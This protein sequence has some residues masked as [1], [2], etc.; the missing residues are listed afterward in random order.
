MKDLLFAQRVSRKWDTVIRGSQALMEALF[1]KPQVPKAFWEHV[2]GPHG[3]ARHITHAELHANKVQTPR[4][5]PGVQEYKSY[6]MAGVL[7]TL[8]FERKSPDYPLATGAFDD[9]Q[10]HFLPRPLTARKEASW[11]RMF[12][13]QPPTTEM[14][15]LWSQKEEG[16]CELFEVSEGVTAGHAMGVL[17]GV[18][19]CYGHMPE[20]Y[21]ICT[22]QVFFAGDEDYEK[23]TWQRRPRLE[24]TL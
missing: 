24:R 15:L 6:A 18:K 8:L 3:G 19:D 17:K 9:Q 13:T 7:N 12:L 22:P 10:Y 5:T 16:N 20:D 1:L 21:Y 23:G 2:S 4:E 11:R 14:Y